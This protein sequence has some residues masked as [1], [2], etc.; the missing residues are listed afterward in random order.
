[1]SLLAFL[2]LACTGGPS[3]TA[4]TSADTS[5]TSACLTDL[6]AGE[7]TAIGT[8]FPDGS[9]GVAFSG[10]V[11]YVSVPDGVMAYDGAAWR[12]V[13]T[14]EHALGLAGAQGGVLVADP[15]AFTFDG[16]GDDG[17]LHY[18]GADGRVVTLAQGM[19]N[20]NFVLPKEDGGILVSDDTAVIYEV[21]GDR[22]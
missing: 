17:R 21:R 22:V 3:D 18:V 11:L 12:R 15:G 7:M 9:E 16:S 19:P 13:A 20:P 2:L 14:L 4:D 10:G 6:P 8:D 5:D 1:M